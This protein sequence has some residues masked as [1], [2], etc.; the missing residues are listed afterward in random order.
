[1]NAS[2]GCLLAGDPVTTVTCSLGTIAAGASK[3]VW[4]EVRTNEGLADPTTINNTAGVT[5]PTDLGA[6]PGSPKEDT[7]DT[8]VNQPDLG[9]VDLMIEKSGIPGT[10]IAGETLTY[11]L[12]VTNTGPADAVSVVVVDALPEG[13]EFVSATTAYPLATCNEGV[14]CALGI[15]QMEPCDDHRGG[16]GKQRPGGRLAELCARAG[17]EQGH[18]SEQ[19]LGRGG[20]GGREEA[21]LSVSKVGTPEPVVAGE[22]LNYKI[23]VSNAGPSDALDVIVTDDFPAELTDISA[24][25]SQG[26]CSSLD[27]LSCNLGAIG[28]G[29]EATITIDAT[30][31]SGV[32]GSIVNTVEVSSS[33]TDPDMKARQRQ[34]R[35]MLN[36]VRIWN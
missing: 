5:S 10:V 14:T 28:A 3:S 25:P 2:P 15:W 8:L 30:V 6:L 18:R 29:E 22:T 35:R 13:V 9:W 19:Q 1:M 21:D 17:F 33:T 36:R 24:E 26:T 4:V 32:T 11:T 12:T 27:P 34:K 16:E 20:H 7:E 31:V 23:V